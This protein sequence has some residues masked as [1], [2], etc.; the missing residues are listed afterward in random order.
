MSSFICPDADITMKYSINGGVTWLGP[1][2]VDV[3][4]D[5]QFFPTITTDSSRATV[6]IAYLNN[7]FDPVFQ[8]LFRVDLVQIIPGSTPPTAPMAIPSTPHHSPRA[9]L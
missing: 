5:D 3:S 8:H 2:N 7:H 9:P 6:N 4:P 1:V